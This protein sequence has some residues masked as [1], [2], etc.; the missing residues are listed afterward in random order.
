MASIIER[1]PYQ[2]QVKV[3]RKETDKIITR[4]FSTKTDAQKWARSVESEMDRGVFVDRTE[5]ERK[6]LGDILKRHAEEVTPTKKGSD[7][8]IIRI[9]T[10]RRDKIANIKMAALSGS[11]IADYRDRRQ[12]DGGVSG[13]TVNR[14]LNL[15][16]SAINTARREWG[17]NCEN[18]VALIRRPQNGKARERRLE[19]GEELRLLKELDETARNPWIKPLVQVAIETAMRRGEMLSLE[20]ENVD[21]RKC[22][23]HLPDTKN[24]EARSIP[25]SSRAKAV[26]EALPRSISGKVFPTTEDAIKKAFSRA[27]ERAG[28]ED[29]RFH[30]LRHEATSRLAELL[31]NLIELAAVTGHKDLRMLKRYYHPRAEDLARKLG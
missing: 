21:L 28:L 30:D 31:P 20:W 12:R 10:I 26:L 2:F 8:E 11:H 25:L 22:V 14:E 4:T 29:L 5:A 19:L 13:S 24:G 18:P 23:A 3:R 27:C 15:I 1:G 6:T 16:S 9:A 7:V 17:V